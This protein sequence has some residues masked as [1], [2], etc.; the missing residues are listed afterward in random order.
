MFWAVSLDVIFFFFNDTATT[1]IYTLSLHE[2]FRSGV[3]GGGGGPARPL[4]ELLEDLLQLGDRDADLLHRIAVADRDV[5]VARFAR[6][7]VTDGLDVHGEAVRGA[8]LVLASVQATD[9]RRV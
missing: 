1:E 4:E 3:A 9:R 5:L 2:L 8:D 7:R 6:L